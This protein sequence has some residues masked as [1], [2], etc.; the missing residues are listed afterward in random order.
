MGRKKGKKIIWGLGVAGTIDKK[1]YKR[2]I[3]VHIK[4]AF[5]FH[6]RSELCQNTPSKCSFLLKKYYVRKHDMF[7]F[8]AI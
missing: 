5:L 3:I 2:V 7:M 4:F 8:S 6:S 1:K